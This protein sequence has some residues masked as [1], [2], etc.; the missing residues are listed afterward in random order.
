[1]RILA[2]TKPRLDRL[3][4]A[5]PGDAPPDGPNSGGLPEGARFV[6]ALPRH[7]AEGMIPSGTR[8]SAGAG[9]P[10]PASDRSARSRSAAT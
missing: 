9:R 2:A 5:S 8:Y 7:P 10:S 1:M 3:T 4:Q 6:G